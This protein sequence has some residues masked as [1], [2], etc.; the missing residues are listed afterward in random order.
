MIDSLRQGACHLWCLP[1]DASSEDLFRGRID[2][3]DQQDLRRYHRYR[4][5]EA[6]RTFLAA[7]VLVRTVLSLYWDVKPADWRFSTNEYGRPHIANPTVPAELHFNLSHK[8]GFV[9]CLVGYD[10]KLGVDVEDASA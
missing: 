10:L 8:P 4:S 2:F 9:V 7:R 3:L 5:L 1:L 6:A